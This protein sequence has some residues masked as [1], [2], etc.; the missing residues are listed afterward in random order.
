LKQTGAVNVHRIYHC[1]VSMHDR[2]AVHAGKTVN[3]SKSNEVEPKRL[4]TDQKTVNH[5]EEE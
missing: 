1:H 2:Q 3:G 5:L 4:S